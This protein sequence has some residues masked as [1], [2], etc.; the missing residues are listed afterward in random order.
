MP[1]LVRQRKF[2]GSCRVGLLPSAS[3]IICVS[4]S[5]VCCQR[6]VFCW[7]IHGKNAATSSRSG[8][9]STFSATSNVY[10][11][12][13]LVWSSGSTVSITS[14]VHCQFCI[15]CVFRNRSA[16]SKPSVHWTVLCRRTFWSSSPSSLVVVT[17]AFHQLLVL[18]FQSFP[19]STIGASLEL[20]ANWR[21]VVATNASVP[22]PEINFGYLRHTILQLWCRG[23]RDSSLF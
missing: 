15:G 13:Q 7:F 3:F 2:G 4:V 11:T 8:L 16:T 22:L 1:I 18:S 17:Y 9:W 23:L 12:Q 20:V 14:S 19:L 10:W 5:D 21:S 6:L